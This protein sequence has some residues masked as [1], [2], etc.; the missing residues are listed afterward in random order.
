M[1]VLPRRFE[2]RERAAEI[3]VDHRLRRE[4]AAVHV[5]LRREVHDGVGPFF[6][7]PAR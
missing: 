6:A 5:R 3:G 2:Q 1:L 4:D 7:R